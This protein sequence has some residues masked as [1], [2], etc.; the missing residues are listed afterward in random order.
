MSCSES[1]LSER[2]KQCNLSP[3]LLHKFMFNKFLSESE[4][5]HIIKN[6]KPFGDYWSDSS[7]YSL[8]EGVDEDI[9]TSLK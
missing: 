1:I 2:A 3:E 9:Q 4:V 5:N 7:E 6:Y 8:E